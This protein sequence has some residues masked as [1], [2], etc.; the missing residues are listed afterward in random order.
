MQ[1]LSSGNEKTDEIKREEIIPSKRWI[2]PVKIEKL[3]DEDDKKSGGASN[4]VR[5]LIPNPLKPSS[6]SSNVVCRFELCSV[7]CSLL[8]LNRV[9]ER[10]NWASERNWERVEFKQ[11]WILN[12]TWMNPKWLELRIWWEWDNSPNNVWFCEV[13]CQWL[14]I[15][16]VVRV[17]ERLKR[18]TERIN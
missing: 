7:T 6:S 14:A 12:Q 11:W 2:A 1:T 15:V 13:L 9:I 10:F 3:E 4:T 18:K 17:I 8:L 16:C 5:S